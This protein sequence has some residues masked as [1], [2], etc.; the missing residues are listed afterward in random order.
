MGSKNAHGCTP[1]AS[2]WTF[3]EKHHKDGDQFL[4]HI[5]RVTGDKTWVSSVNVETRKQSK[6]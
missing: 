2:A 6:Q 3:L 1:M 5:I 4:Y